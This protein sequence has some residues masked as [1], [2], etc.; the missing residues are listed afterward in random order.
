M[1]TGRNLVLFGIL[2]FTLI[3]LFRF[4]TLRFNHKLRLVLFFSLVSWVSF[5]GSLIRIY[6][7]SHVG[8][9]L[10]NLFPLLLSVGAGQ[11]LP[12]PEPSDSSNESLCS[13][14]WI[15]DFYGNKGEASSDIPNQA[16][17]Q[18][19]QQNVEGEGSSAPGRGGY[20]DDAV[21]PF[22]R[23]EGAGPSAPYAPQPDL[24]GVEQPA[25]LP[26]EVDPNDN[27]TQV[28]EALK[29]G[30]HE[31][32]SKL[33]R[34]ESEKGGARNLS[35]LIPNSHQVHGRIADLVMEDLELGPNDQV[36]LADLLDWR[37]PALEEE[38]HIKS[39]IRFKLKELN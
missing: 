26:A 27:N 34:E 29:R 28:I 17:P 11:A 2:I 5:L 35:L 24:G 39:L 12:L 16:A 21:R 36:N 32:I 37:F 23:A 20:L 3:Y 31:R 19:V 38:Q 18:T 22:L 8:L 9:D 13:G 4:Y 30:I 15:Q 33:V 1:T 7:F 6:L 10:T 14:S 25:L